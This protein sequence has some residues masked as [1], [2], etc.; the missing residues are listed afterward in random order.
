MIAETLVTRH[1]ILTIPSSS[2]VAWSYC[3]G[4][5]VGVW[6]ICRKGQA[7]DFHIPPPLVFHP[8]RV[9]STSW[10]RLFSLLIIFPKSLFG[11]GNVYIRLWWNI[12]LYPG[13]T[14]S[15]HLSPSEYLQLTLNRVYTNLTLLF[16]AETHQVFL[17][18]L[19]SH[20][21]KSPVPVDFTSKTSLESMHFFLVTLLPN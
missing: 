2:E 3:W 21:I 12:S 9:F 5:V 20:P 17:L 14:L 19:Y 11:F 18:P 13:L 16:N 6:L 8:W 7:P 4:V 10:F 15:P 1:T